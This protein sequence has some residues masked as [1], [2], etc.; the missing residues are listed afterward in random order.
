MSAIHSLNPKAEVAKAAAALAVNISA[1]KGLQDVLKTNLGPKGEAI[2]L[3]RFLP[4]LSAERVGKVVMGEG[5][6]VK[7]EWT[8]SIQKN[9]SY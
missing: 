8:A 9:L 4:L 5:T 6:M 2:V 3:L 7:A 1:A